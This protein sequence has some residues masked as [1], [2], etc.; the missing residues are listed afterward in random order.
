MSRNYLATHVTSAE[1]AT[2]AARVCQVVSHER[3]ISSTIIHE[4]NAPASAQIQGPTWLIR[5]ADGLAPEPDL[6]AAD[7][8]WIAPGLLIAHNA[9]LRALGR[10]PLHLPAP[11]PRWLANLA[12]IAPELTGRA[13]VTAQ[14]HEIRSWEHFPAELG[15]QSSPWSQLARGRVSTFRAARRSL[16]ALQADLAAAPADS[17]IQISGQVDKISEEWRVIVSSSEPVAASGYCIHSPAGSQ[18]IL[19]VFD[20]A[21]FDPAHRER[22]LDA[23]RQAARITGLDSASIDL[24]FTSTGT[25]SDSGFSADSSSAGSSTGGPIVLEVNPLWCAAPY[26]YGPEGMARFLEAIR[27]SEACAREQP[28]ALSRAEG[29]FHPDPWMESEF[30]RRYAAFASPSS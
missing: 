19:S 15:T 4:L 23:A 11:S 12:A 22:A 2:G 20:G 1:S 10:E 3:W 25:D 7:A 24:A 6:E 29:I 18:Q 16:G 5:S 21:H 27:K 14:A 30:S 26:E 17:L 28:E 13:V 9:W 8:L